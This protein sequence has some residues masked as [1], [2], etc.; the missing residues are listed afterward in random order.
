MAVMM[1]SLYSALTE[2]GAS[3]DVARLAAEDVAACGALIDGIRSDLFII[4]CMTICT[5]ALTV[6]V[7]A[8]LLV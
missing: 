1:G 3:A 6:A 5:L 2:A 8:K 4:K 7:L